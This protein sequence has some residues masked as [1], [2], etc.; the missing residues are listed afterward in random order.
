MLLQITEDLLINE[1]VIHQVM[2]EGNR[3]HVWFISMEGQM[4]CQ[5][6]DQFQGI[7]LWQMLCKVAA[8]NVEDDK[9]LDFDPD[10]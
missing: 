5:V 6:V 9:D 7:E 10:F 2:R 8:Q 4:V 3:I 1:D